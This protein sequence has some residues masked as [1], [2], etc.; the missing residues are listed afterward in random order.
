M[1][2]ADLP[3]H[4]YR[5]RSALLAGC[6]RISTCGWTC[7]LSIAMVAIEPGSVVWI[8]STESNTRNKRDRCNLRD[9]VGHLDVYLK[10][11]ERD[12]H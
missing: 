6:S 8:T 7:P 12:T 10:E 3:S 4:S 9:I 5:N 1:L 11:R 2:P